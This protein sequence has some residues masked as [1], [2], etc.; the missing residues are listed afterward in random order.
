MGSGADN[1]TIVQLQFL[2]FHFL[3]CWLFACLVTDEIGT[4]EKPKTLNLQSGASASEQA[5]PETPGE[6]GVVITPTS[7]GCK[8]LNAVS[9]FY[10]MSMDLSDTETKSILGM[11]SNQPPPPPLCRK[12]Y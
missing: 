3:L 11:G 6:N 2:V 9:G 12:L 1:Q 10:H 5:Q 4:G 8:F 7:P